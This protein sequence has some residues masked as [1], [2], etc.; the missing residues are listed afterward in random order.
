M[1]L[2]R[3]CSV[4]LSGFYRIGEITLRFVTMERQVIS[5]QSK[6]H[7]GFDIQLSLPA[8]PN[9]SYGT[10]KTPIPSQGGSPVFSPELHLRKG[11]L[12]LF[13]GVPLFDVSDGVKAFAQ[14]RFNFNR[15]CCTS[16]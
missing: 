14:T 4:L 3:Y 11:S 9:A 10:D 12:S 7:R 2:A 8:L 1:R 5:K 16:L 6:R 15:T 13:L